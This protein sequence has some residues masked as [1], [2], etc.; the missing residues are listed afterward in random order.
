MSIE[1]LNL[2]RQLEGGKLLTA[3]MKKIGKDY[4][5]SSATT[6]GVDNYKKKFMECCEQG[7]CALIQYLVQAA[8]GNF[9]E[10]ANSNNTVTN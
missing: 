4:L 1:Y 3:M 5:L 10:D 2:Q 6:E 9:E 7:A 8:E